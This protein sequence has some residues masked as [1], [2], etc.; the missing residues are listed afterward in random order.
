MQKLR[1]EDNLIAGCAFVPANVA[2]RLRAF[3]DTPF[4]LHRM[5]DGDHRR[6]V[7]RTAAFGEPVHH[8]SSRLF[9]HRCTALNP[10]F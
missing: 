6:S 2:I 5:A 10:S 4:S 1:Q 8:L 9:G 3:N 7:D